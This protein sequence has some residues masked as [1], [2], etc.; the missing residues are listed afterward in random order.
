ML[1]LKFSI[2]SVRNVATTKGDGP[3]SPHDSRQFVMNHAGW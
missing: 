3:T 2:L 1:C